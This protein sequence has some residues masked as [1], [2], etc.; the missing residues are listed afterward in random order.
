MANLERLEHF[1][2][3]QHSYCFIG[4]P[5][6]LLK[7]VRSLCIHSMNI[8]FKKII[9]TLSFLGLFSLTSIS[10]YASK[11]DSLYQAVEIA[12]EDTSKVNLLLELCWQLHRID[13]NKIEGLANQSLNLS[14]QLDFQNGIG[15]SYNYLSWFNIS[16]ANYDKALEFSLATVQIAEET[17]NEAL[18][19]SSYNDVARIYSD[20]GRPDEALAIWQNLIDIKLKKGDEGGAAVNYLNMAILL[21]IN[22]NN[23]EAHKYFLQALDAAQKSKK[24][25]IKSAAHLEV[26]EMYYNEGNINDAELNYTQALE[27]AEKGGDIWISAFSILGLSSINLDKGYKEIA[28]SQARKAVTLTEQIGDNYAL[29]KSKSKLAQILQKVDLYEESLQV[30][31]FI[32]EVAEKNKLISDRLQAYLDLSVTYQKIEDYKNAFLFSE[33]YHAL[34]DSTFSKEKAKNI[35]NLEKKYQSDLKEKENTVLKL[36]QQEQE[37]QIKQNSTFN[38]TLLLILFLLGIVGFSIYRRYINKISAHKIL[39][40]KVAERTEELRLMN[41]NLETSNKELERFAYIASH[42]L[43]EPLR[44][45]SGFAGL[46]KKELKPE[47]GSTVDEYLSFISNNTSQLSTLIQDILAYSKLNQE[48]DEIT[49]VDPNFIIRDINNSLA[50]SIKEK[51]VKIFIKGTLPQLK[52]SGKQVYFLF[53]NLIENGIKYNNS[54][55]PRIDI[56]CKDLGDKHE[57]SI[58]DNGIGVDPEY[59]AKIFEMFTRLHNREQFKGTGLGL[60]LCK[61]IVENHGGTITVESNEGNGSSF[62]FTWCKNFTG[63]VLEDKV[64]ENKTANHHDT[65]YVV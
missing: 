45:I 26:A 47:S 23:K 13:V 14:Q 3:Y 32:V 7:K 64:I 17:D 29:L 62:I 52:S 57:F 39:E 44:N 60:S 10:A 56:L 43:R 27:I 1:L 31:F 40:E 4:I 36:Q 12:Q 58:K 2:I 59:S 38:N 18:Y 11:I 42:D 19:V 22:E 30:N 35:L 8:I 51:K 53:K 48:V 34:Q 63:E 5:K 25:M 49:I 20:I 37:L 28:L 46:L 55:F 41:K 9:F 6:K 15:Q 65:E 50:H 16:Q 24:D 61:K 33:K 21:K 54:S